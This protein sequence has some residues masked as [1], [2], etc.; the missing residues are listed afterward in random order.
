MWYKDYELML[1]LHTKYKFKSPLLDAG[2][3]EMPCIADY[4]ISKKKAYRSTLQVGSHI[5]NI[6]V[7]HENQRDRYRSIHRPWN[8][9]DKDYLILNPENGDPLIEELPY[10]YTEKFNM[11]IVVSVFEH[12]TDPFKCSDAIFRILKPGG[13]LFNSTPFLFPIHD[14]VD[15]WR[16]SPRALQYMHE[17]SGFQWLEGDYHIN[18]KSTDGIGDYH[19][20]DEVQSI[21]GCYALCRK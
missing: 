14:V 16:Y 1:R 17:Q 10:L 6:V 15:N 11:V 20:A 7:P 12:V 8:F 9:I 3:L 19:N 5:R 2:G 18:Y 13:Y 21:I 4:E